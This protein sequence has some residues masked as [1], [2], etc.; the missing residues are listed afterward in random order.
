M[1]GEKISHENIRENLAEI[2]HLILQAVL[3]FV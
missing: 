3:D 1:C 2:S